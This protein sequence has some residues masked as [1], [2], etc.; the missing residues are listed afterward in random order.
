MVSATPR[1]LYP[2]EKDSVSVVQAAAWASGQVWTDRENVAPVGFRTLDLPARSESVYRLPY[3][4]PQLL[5]SGERNSSKHRVIFERRKFFG[6]FFVIKLR[7]NRLEIHE[8]IEQGMVISPKLSEKPC[9]GIN[10]SIINPISNASFRRPAV[11]YLLVFSRCRGS[12]FSLDHTQT[13][14]SR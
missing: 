8:C 11:F 1:P 5:A 4:G 2:W 10:M 13:H 6:S 14:H 7:W 9:C 12:S 3:P